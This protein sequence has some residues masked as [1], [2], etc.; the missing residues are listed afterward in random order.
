MC[1]IAG[2]AGMADKRAAAER[3][4]RMT[5]A[6]ALRGPDGEGLETWDAAALG[7]RRLA[8][9]DLSEA[10]SQ[11]MCAPDRRTGVV[12]NGAIYN[13][14]ELRTELEAEGFRFRSNTDTEVLVHGYRA[15]GIDRLTNRLR[16][17]FAFGLWDDERRTLFL[18]RDRLGVK[19]LV[20]ARTTDG[21]LAFA[22][23]ARALRAGGFA[24]EIDERGIVEYLEF[25]FITDGRSIYKEV[26]K[27]PAATILE[28]N[29]ATDR[30]TTREYWTPPEP[31]SN[32]RVTFEEAVE[33]TEELFLQAVERR[34]F[35]D[36]PVGALLS[37]GVDSSLVCWAIKEKGGDVTAYT[38]GTPND[39]MDETA[40]ARATANKLGIKHE[41]LNLSADDAPD[42]DELVSA[43]GEPFAC[44]SALG[45]LRISRVVAREITV[46]LTGDGGDDVFLGYPEHK[47]FHLAERVARRTPE[48]LARLWYGLRPHLSEIS[49]LRRVSSFL[50]YTTGGLGG[51]TRRR[52]GL[53]VYQRNGLLGERLAGARLPQREIALS[54]QAARRLLSDFLAYDRKTRFTGEYLP[55]VD[56]ATMRY[57]VEAR[58]PFLDQELWEYAAGLPFDIR[59]QSGTLK[60]VLREI[61]RRRIGERVAGGGKRGFGVP[62]GRW[63]VGRWREG[64][65]QSLEDSALAG[66]GWIKPEPVRLMLDRAAQGGVAPNQLWYIYVLERWLKHERHVADESIADASRSSAEPAPV[67]ATR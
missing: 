9:F 25:G 24:G 55:K 30:L 66:A 43:F 23:T 12:F 4:R 34:L 57:A 13:F 49:A 8:I 53:P 1:G 61:A 29:A 38:I 14:R 3:V 39:P 6:L 2:A 26:D 59:L 27:L 46:L 47:A 11:P 7:H 45:M 52:E 16:G 65:E 48:G 54:P 5:C 58:S 62:V 20:Y 21:A 17:M 19:P 56:G 63:L 67:L 36:V 33:R 44:A 22:S 35:A 37:G 51:V 18:V 41:I 64:F 60:A 32:T 10:G 42:V 50:N 28:W 40:D 15:W 31:G